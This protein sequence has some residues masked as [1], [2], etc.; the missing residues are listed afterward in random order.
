MYQ[1]TIHHELISLAK[2]YPVISVMGPRQSGKTTVVKEVF[3]E[4][5]YANL[6][7]PD[8]RALAQKDPRHFLEQFENGAILDEIQYVPELLSY[9]QAIVDEK[10]HAGMFVITGS[11]QLELHQAVSQS[12]AGRVGLLTLYPL[13]I[14]E[15]RLA[16]IDLELDEQIYHGFY[17]RIYAKQLNPTKAY[18]NY[19]STY[20]ER[21]VRQLS[22]IKDLI[23]FQNFMKLCAGRIGQVIDY[24][25]MGNDLGV[26]NNTVKHW[27]SI[28]EASYIIYRLKPY[29]ENFGKRVIKSPKLYFTDVGLAAYL[30]D[31]DRPEQIARDPLRGNL[32]ENVVVM[33]LCKYRHNRGLDP[34]LYY[35]RD[36]H[37][38]E[39]DI[40]IKQANQLMPIEV[41][42]AKTFKLEFL[43]G[44]KFYRKLIG[45]RCHKGYLV[46]SGDLTQEVDGFRILNYKDVIVVYSDPS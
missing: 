35:Y 40:I 18:R 41:K 16:N 39:V 28:L 32:V 42:S 6:E 45:E 22:N 43:K 34:N 37:K 46:Y 26:S 36:N 1:R 29:F 10:Q 23:L 4:K 21:D 33:E 30:L 7:E 25:S 44:L 2:D 24:V 17:P 8:Q 38:N 9:I 3:A 27:F 12:L 20:L 31:I 14:N 11:H 5:P 15:L 13:T 19:V